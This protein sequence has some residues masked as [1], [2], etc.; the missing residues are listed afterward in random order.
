MIDLL[1]VIPTYVTLAVYVLGFL[2][3]PLSLTGGLLFKVLGCCG[4]SGCCGP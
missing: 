3:V 1:A 4:C 2:G